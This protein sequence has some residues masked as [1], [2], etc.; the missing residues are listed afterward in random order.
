MAKSNSKNV[1]T[2]TTAKSTSAT[3]TKK[4]DSKQTSRKGGDILEFLPVKSIEK[5]LITFTNGRYGR[6]IKVGSLNISYLSLDEQHSKMRQLATV[7]N[8]I[9]ADC[10]I[11]KLERKLDL[12]NSLNKQSD[13][14]GLL[15]QK[16]AEKEM[17]EK[18]YIERK[19]QMGF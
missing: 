5:G 4:I 8:T 6:V 9:N 3:A 10:S 12:T 17:T 14:F 11:L 15:E 1:A 7:F 19:N 16:Y 2:K 13:L 18:G